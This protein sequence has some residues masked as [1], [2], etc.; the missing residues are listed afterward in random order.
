MACAGFTCSKTSLCAINIL[1]V[2]V[3][4]LMIGI[5]AWGKW[6]GLVS[7]F[8]VVGGVI[9]VGVFLFL[10]AVVGLVGAIKHHQVLLFFYMIVLF[11]V[12]VVQFSVSCACLAITEEQQHQL[13]EIG[14][15]DSQ[16]TQRDVEK[17][18]D[19]CGFSSVNYNGTCE[20]SCFSSHNCVPCAV[21]IQQHADDVLHFVG[22]IGLFFSFTEILG[23][24]LTYRYRNQ[25]DPRANPSAFL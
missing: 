12:F 21:T 1:Y 16:T 17:N 23:V 18:I 9:G 15:N 8:Q 19:C 24:W 14:W 20:A 22:G 5:A 25:K 7:S 6:F 2:M 11:M 4:L 3:S 10:V 13:L